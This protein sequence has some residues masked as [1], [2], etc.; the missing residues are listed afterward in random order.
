MTIEEIAAETERVLKMGVALEALGAKK[1]AAREKLLA[2]EEKFFALNDKYVAE[3]NALREKKV[4]LG[5]IVNCVPKEVQNSSFGCMNCMY[6]SCE[7][8]NGVNY[9]PRTTSSGKPSCAGYVYYD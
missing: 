9:K 2:I 3:Y 7:C 6:A 1:K 4:A 8:K 5:V